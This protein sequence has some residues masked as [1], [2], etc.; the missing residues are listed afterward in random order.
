VIGHLAIPDGPITRSDLLL[1][2]V[3][4]TTSAT[5]IRRSAALGAGGFDETFERAAGVEDLDLWFRLAAVGP[6][7]GAAAVCATYVV[8]EGRDRA[9]SRAELAALE[10]DRERVVARLADVPAPLARRATAVMR[11]RTARYWLLAGQA[12][13]A[14]RAAAASL[15]AAP[16]PEGLVTFA[17][18]WVPPPARELARRARRTARARSVRR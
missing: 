9:R 18:T 8:H 13:P 10:R 14:R 2:R 4:P 3:V 16:T 1:G 11:A 15:R 17:A 6:C 5:L 7:V 12:R